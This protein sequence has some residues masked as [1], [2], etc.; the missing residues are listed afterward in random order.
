FGL[1]G[2]EPASRNH[3]T[4][5]FQ[6]GFSWSFGKH[7]MKFGGDMALVFVKDGIPVDPRGTIVFFPT[8]GGTCENMPGTTTHIDCNSLT[9]YIDNFSGP[10]GTISKFFGNSIIHPFLPNYAP[11]IQDSWRI[12][13][14]LTLDLGLRYEYWG[15]PGNDLQFPSLDSRFGQGL[16]GA[17]F[18]GAFAAQQ[19]GDKNNF[20]PRVG[21]AYTPPFL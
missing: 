2:N 10:G 19:Q 1:P 11:Y 8:T 5:Q 9:N 6:D 16:A 21:L 12:K 18:P 14:N 4:Y 17:P 7:T 20:A 13:Q 3:Q 15:T